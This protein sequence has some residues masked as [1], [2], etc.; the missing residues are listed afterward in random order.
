[1]TARVAWVAAL[2]LLLAGCGHRGDRTP[3][4]ARATYKTQVDG[5]GWTPLSGA[6]PSADRLAPLAGEP[7]FAGVSSAA[8]AGPA[9]RDAEQY[10]LR[11]AQLLAD[12]RPGFSGDD[13]LRLVEAPG[14]RRIDREFAV[15]DI[16][17]QRRLGW[18]R[19]FDLTADMWIRSRPRGAA[20]APER[21]DVEVLGYLASGP[22]RP[23]FWCDFDLGIVR[24]RQT[25]RVDAITQGGASLTA[26]RHLTPRR[27]PVV[28]PGTG[29]RRVPPA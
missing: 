18:Q 29:W 5:R 16:D 8:G 13:V 15:E 19:H 26:A 28:L 3:P 20:A 23:G 9:R 11:V 24:Y 12:V 17:G 1:V 27:N 21:V 6:V 10:A 2:L 14:L 7:T 4:P 25:W 22:G